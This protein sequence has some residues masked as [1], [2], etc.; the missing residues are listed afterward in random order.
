[1]TGDVTGSGGVTGGG[2]VVVVAEGFPRLAGGAGFSVA[3]PEA[4]GGSTETGTGWRDGGSG[5]LS[6]GGSAGT[7][8]GVRA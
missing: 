4:A 7:A 8:A 2:V 3:V 6:V 1:M 5:V